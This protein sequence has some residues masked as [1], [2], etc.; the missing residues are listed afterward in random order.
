MSAADS[1]LALTEE[2]DNMLLL[3]GSLQ[4]KEHSVSVK[5]NIPLLQLGIK[6]QKMLLQPIYAG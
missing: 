2:K 5:I 1:V 3:V 4:S 6:A